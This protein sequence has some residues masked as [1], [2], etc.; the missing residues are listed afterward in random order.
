MRNT[1]ILMKKKLKMND[2]VI[3]KLIFNSLITGKP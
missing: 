3:F 2:F 1:E